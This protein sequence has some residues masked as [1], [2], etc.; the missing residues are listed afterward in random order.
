VL[1]NGLKWE[2]MA[3]IK[4]TDNLDQEQDGS[5][6]ADL[7]RVSG[8]YGN[9]EHSID[10]KGRVALPSNFRALLKPEDS[11]T[12]VLTNFITDGARCLDGFSLSAWKEFESK[13][14]QRSRFDPAIRNFETYYIA[15]ACLCVWDSNG[16]I[17]IPQ[18]LRDYAGIEKNLVFTAALHGFRIW[19]KEVWDL[20]FSQSE[21]DL[22][23]NPEL[24]K[25]VD[26]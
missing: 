24:F 11:E 21:S 16:R 14:K 9:F 4:N 18:Y 2:Q 23:E 20:I 13:I 10:S 22:L 3:D 19:R 25:G 6:S 17:N 15:R 5:I 1:G 7:N 26:L 12:I 8:F